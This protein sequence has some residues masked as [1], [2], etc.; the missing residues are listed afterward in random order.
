MKKKCILLKNQNKITENQMCKL[1]TQSPPSYLT[2]CSFFLQKHIFEAR[3]LSIFI[4]VTTLSYRCPLIYSFMLLSSVA[5]A[6]VSPAS[7]EV[8]AACPSQNNETKSCARQNQLLYSMDLQANRLFS[9]F[10]HKLHLNVFAQCERVYQAIILK[11]H[12]QFQKNNY[13]FL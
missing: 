2:Y 4:M 5:L 8:K 1:Y 12:I 6:A 7:S 11:F 13:T 9:T 10:L 3:Y